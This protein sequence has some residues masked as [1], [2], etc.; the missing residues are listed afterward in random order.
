MTTL[1]DQWTEVCKVDI[2]KAGGSAAI[3]FGSLT[4]TVDIDWGE[5]AVE[6][7]ALVNGGR[8]VTYTPETPTVIRL[9]MVPVGTAASATP[10]GLTQWFM[11]DDADVT[12]PLW[13]VNTRTRILF[14]VVLLW[15]DDAAN[16]VASGV[17]AA[18]TSSLRFSFWRC[19][20]TSLKIAFTDDLLK[21][22][23]EFT[24]I[25]F[26]KTASGMIASEE[27][28]NTA[29]LALA[30]FTATAVPTTA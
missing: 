3:P 16:T 7:T 26:S 27:A 9:E 28:S 11:G 12:Q 4:D 29:L 30:T 5:K 25:P 13:T 23:A 19:Y 21:A 22:T 2:T 15:T 17:T 6:Q 18:S 10:T 1:P 8:I 14:R 20:L 24:C